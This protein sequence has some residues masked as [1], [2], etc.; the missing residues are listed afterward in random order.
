[1]E[2]PIFAGAEVVGMET[3]SGVG[4]QPMG[5]EMTILGASNRARACKGDAD[6]GVGIE[7]GLIETPGVNGGKMNVQCCAI[8][9]GEHVYHGMSSMHGITQAVLE[10]MEQEPGLQ[11]DH[12][13][14]RVGET[15]DA[16]VGK[17][18]GLI[19]IYTKGRIDRR[20]MI[21]QGLRMAMIH[22]EK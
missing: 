3:D 16:R 13:A 11:L 15:G 8:F 7:G 22:I 2:Y 19:H 5:M 10:L 6:F 9:D 21:R 17:A 20:E 4:E 12:A 14:H 18:K 1:M